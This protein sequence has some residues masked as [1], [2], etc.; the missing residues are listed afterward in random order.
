MATGTIATNKPD[1]STPDSS[2][3]SGILSH[4]T[5]DLVAS[6]VVFLIALPLCMGIAIASGVPPALG[7]I[8]GIIGGIVVGTIS[9]SPLQVSGP[10]AGL[11]VIVFEI[12]QKFGLDVLGPILLLAGSLQLIGG[13]LKLGRWFRAI[14]PAVI[15][16]MLSGIGILIIAGQFHVM[17]DDKPRPSGMANLLAIPVSL[18]KGLYPPEGTVHHLAA[19]VGVATLAA[20]LLWN[21]FKPQALRVLPGT[22]VGVVTGTLLAAVLQLP[23]RH[24]DLPENLFSSFALPTG[25]SL[26]RL[27]DP[28][29]LFAA[30]GIAIVA[31]AETLLSASAVDRMHTGPRANY[32]RELSAQGIGN[33]LCGMFGALPMTGVIVRSSANVQAGA[34]TRLSAIFHGVW[35]LSLVMFF[36]SVLELIPTA[37]LAAILVFTGFKLI[38]IQHVKRLAEYGKFPL[39]IYAATIIG[40]VGKDLL[41]GVMIGL[42]LTVLKVLIKVTKL[43]VDMVSE[44]NSR[45]VDITL[46]GVLTFL[47]LPKLHEI[48]DNLPMDRIIHLH[49]EHLRYIDHTCFDMLQA[50][51]AQRAEQGG[52]VYA[53]W[54]VLS[55]RFHLKE[56]HATR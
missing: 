43:E 22:L 4:V 32:D 24:V 42:G 55:R 17:V 46:H 28:A 47:R 34:K 35:L 33:A 23:I 39:V 36:P 37:S 27:F 18:W 9:G 48:F 14:S 2:A 56:A 50:A 13:W 15:Y 5:N 29:I 25:G 40:I 53:P 26:G 21:K 52:A 45:R 38:E 8:T 16:G 1:S 54:D 30:V 6:L 19:A 49:I 7:I 20:I 51:A 11:S 10:A 3:R 31:S 12:V 41:T 44:E